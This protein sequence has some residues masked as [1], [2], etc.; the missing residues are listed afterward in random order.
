MDRPDLNLLAELDALLQTESVG[1]AAALLEL[2]PSARNHAR[3]GLTVTSRCR[4]P[5]AEGA[6]FVVRRCP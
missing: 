1:G 2:S 6:P 4:P 5:R 3:R